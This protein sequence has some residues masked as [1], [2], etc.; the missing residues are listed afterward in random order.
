[1]D[2]FQKKLIALYALKCA[3]IA[4]YLLVVAM[5]GFASELLFGQP[6][7]GVI[8][9]ALVLL[10]DSRESRGRSILAFRPYRRTHTTNRPN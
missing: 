1:M 8:M 3:V 4:E 7:I 10:L 5:I 2:Y 9:A 6:V